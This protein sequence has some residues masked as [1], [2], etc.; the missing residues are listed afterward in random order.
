V[1]RILASVSPGEIRIAVV[2]ADAGLEDFTIWRPGAPEAIGDIHIARITARVPAMAGAFASLG[3]GEGFLPDSEGAANLGIG[4]AVIVRI[5][6]A[7]QGGKGPRISARLDTPETLPADATPRR[8]RRG[9]SPLHR[10]A[11]SLPAAPIIVDGAAL[12]AELRPAFG[13]R[14]TR[15]DAAFDAALDSAIDELAGP[16]IA[17]PGSMRAS[18][19]PTPALVAIDVDGGASTAASGTKAATQMAANRA[20]LPALARQIR[21]RNLGG[22]ILIDFA[23]LAIKRR[24]ALGPALE[25]AFASDPGK[26]RLLGF[27]Q[28][29]L[30]EILRPRATAPL[31]EVLAGPHAAGLAALRQI[32]GILRHAPASRHRLRAAPGIAEALRADPVALPDLARRAT[33]PLILQGDP[34]LPPGRWVIEDAA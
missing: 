23:G 25:A 31:H 3:G 5:S 13:D 9:P 22:A 26:P 15:V 2:S 17:L 34:A 12:F 20:A 16:E 8:L 19:T 11:A 4:D 28:L 27:T 6:R 32:A 33:H 18:I 7:A 24:A 30:A 1:R 21:L 29:G 10:L 14:L